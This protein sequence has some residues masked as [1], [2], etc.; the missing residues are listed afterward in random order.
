MPTKFE[1]SDFLS[2]HNT[3]FDVLLA[4]P[5]RALNNKLLDLMKE[6]YQELDEIKRAYI[7]KQFTTRTQE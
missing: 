6:E 3:S 2:F 4:N 7:K 1:N 5:Q